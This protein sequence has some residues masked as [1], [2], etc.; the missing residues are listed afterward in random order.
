M[1]W[2]VFTKAA[3]AAPGVKMRISSRDRAP[4][5]GRPRERTIEK[6]ENFTIYFTDGAI[7]SV[8]DAKLGG[9]EFKE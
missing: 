4:I 3:Q 9:Y 1:T 5:T 6:R 8:S 2:L 7:L